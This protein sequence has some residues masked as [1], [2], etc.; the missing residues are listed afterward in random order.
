MS[1]M[2]FRPLFS[3]SGV[4]VITA[5]F[6]MLLLGVISALMVNLMTTAHRTSAQDVEGSRAYFAARAGVEWGMA[7]LDPNAD[8]VAVPACFADTPL[9][10]IPGFTVTVKC[11]RN[12][13][14]EAGRNIGVYEITATAGNGAAAPPE[15]VERQ[16]SVTTER[17]RDPERTVAPYDC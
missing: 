1:R 16:I 14:G 5:V 11:S 15:A 12:T 8:N 7:Q 2:P 4:S 3:Q 6:I 9:T 10:Q 17:C 13:Y